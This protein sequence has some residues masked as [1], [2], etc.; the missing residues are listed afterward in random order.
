[1]WTC[2]QCGQ[3]CS[4]NSNYCSNCGAEKTTKQH[5]RS[6]KGMPKYVAVILTGL[7]ICAVTG[8]RLIN[9][10]GELFHT[11]GPVVYSWAD[12]N[13]NVSATRQCERNPD[14]IQTEIV[15]TTYQITD[16]PTCGKEGT[17]IYSA[18]FTNWA[19]VTQ[20]KCVSIE[21]Q[22]HNWGTVTYDWNYNHNSITAIRV[23]LNDPTHIESETVSSKKT[24]TTAATCLS[25]GKTTYSASFSNKA[26]ALQTTTVEDIEPYGHNWQAATYDTP[27]TCSRC[28]LQEGTVKGYLGWLEGSFND[29]AVYLRGNQSSGAFELKERVNNCFRLTICLEITEYSGSPFGTWS[30]FARDFNGRWSP[31]SEF[32]ITKDFVDS[33]Q[34]IR[35][36]FSTDASFDALSL[37][38]KGN[39]DFSVDYNVRYIDAQVR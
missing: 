33:E 39:V 11:W 4:D 29:Q 16:P 30:L 25:K 35:L 15:K 31:I 13:S 38:K 5:N 8:V 32:E 36:D 24:V 37:V 22:A 10:D 27:K 1:M 19:F 28:G 7:L 20:E 26:F 6:T 17:A 3:R 21:K 18:R 14:H 23:C 9:T 2:K 12:D 34:E